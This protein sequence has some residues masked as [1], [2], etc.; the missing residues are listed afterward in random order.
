MAARGSKPLVAL[1]G[2]LDTK[3]AEYQFAT[4]WLEKH[5]CNVVV[6]DASTRSPFEG[7]LSFDLA[8][9]SKLHRPKDLLGTHA[10]AEDAE[11][12][13][14][15][16]LL[17][18]ACLDELTS[19]QARG[20]LNSIASFGGS[21]N[22]AFATSIMRSPTFPIGLP[23]FMLATMASGDVSEYLGESDICIMPSVA[24]ISGSMNDITLTTLQSALAAI[25][26]MAHMHHGAKQDKSSSPAEEKDHKPMIAISMFGV[27]TVA[28]NQISDLLK[29]RGYEPVAFHATGSG[30]RSMERLIRE[31]FFAGVVDLTTT[32]VCDQ[33]YN[34]VLSAGPDRLT[35]AAECGVP[36]VVSVGALDMINFGSLSSLP[37]RIKLQ[38]SKDDGPMH[39]TEDGT[40]VYEHNSQ[41]TLVR[42]SAAQCKEIGE[43]IVEKL[44]TGLSRLQKGRNAAPVRILFPRE[45][46]SAM[47]GAE[48]VWNNP[49]A[50]TALH[51]S[52]R[53]ALKSKA[54]QSNLQSSV[55]IEAFEHHINSAEFAMIV[56]DQAAQLVSK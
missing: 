27:T 33:L 32:E 28:V 8:A 24:D 49:E 22:T 17:R 7:P 39:Y 30:G 13:K 47:D 51:G 23:K 25:S 37:S 43:Y 6:L 55:T 53:E 41:V 14:V 12:S 29:E 31:G 48:G 2:T 26:G 20:E 46:L 21:Q 35:A 1:I 56:A 45:G 10:F 38:N 50:R 16:E 11:R 9:S 52:I 18:E 54:S 19:L 15:R 34:G 3:Q 36:Q 5:N 42:T 44:T 4:S 40:P